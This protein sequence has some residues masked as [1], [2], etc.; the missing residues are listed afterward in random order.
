VAA[1]EPPSGREIVGGTTIA[2]QLEISL[3]R[4]GFTFCYSIFS[5]HLAL[6]Q[7]IWLAMA[8]PLQTP[9]RLTTHQTRYNS[10][11]P[12]AHNP[13]DRLNHQLLSRLPANITG[14]RLPILTRH[15][16]WG[17]T[18]LERSHQDLEA[19]VVVGDGP[20]GLCAQA[21]RACR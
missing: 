16:R 21:C 6:I 3:L 20:A 2:M 10:N 4:S 18:L 17:I 5:C 8:S 14:R 13:D 9:V 15:D 1:G 19:L 7:Y 12:T 11:R